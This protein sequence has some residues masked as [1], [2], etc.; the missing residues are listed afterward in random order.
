MNYKKKTP[1]I[2]EILKTADPLAMTRSIWV[3]LLN[4]D[5]DKEKKGES[6]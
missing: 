1:T 4:K 2:E 3:E 6:E 5:S